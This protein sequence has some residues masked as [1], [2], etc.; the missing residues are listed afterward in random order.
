MSVSPVLQRIFLN[1]AKK[2]NTQI[3]F[4]SLGKEQKEIWKISN[5]PWAFEC[6]GRTEHKCIVENVKG[7]ECDPVQF[8]HTFQDC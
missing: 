5:L 7:K 2:G 3:D 8:F 6:H 4:I 1:P